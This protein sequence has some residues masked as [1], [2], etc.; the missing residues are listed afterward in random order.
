MGTPCFVLAGLQEPTAVIHLIS[1]NAETVVY[2][3]IKKPLPTIYVT[4]N[5]RQQFKKFT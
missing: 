1:G 5:Y 2:L 4:R 3:K